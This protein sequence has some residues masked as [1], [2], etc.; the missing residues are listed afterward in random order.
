MKSKK[1]TNHNKYRDLRQEDNYST[2]K[3]MN[4][5][6]E[7]GTKPFFVNKSCTPFQDSQLRLMNELIHD[8]FDT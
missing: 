6:N 7:E 2:N 3:W 8:E 4:L 5:W 1:Y